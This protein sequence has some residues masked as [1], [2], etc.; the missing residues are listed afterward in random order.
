MVNESIQSAEVVLISE[1]GENVGTVSREQAFFI[2][3]ELGLD[4]VVVSNKS[5]P[6]V[7]RLKDVG[8]ERYELEKRARKHKAAQRSGELKE[9]QLSFRID[10]HDFQTKLRHAQRFLAKGDRIKLFMRL[11]GRENAFAEQAKQ[12]IQEFATALGK[13]VDTLDKQGSRITAI[14]K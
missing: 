8:K 6:P 9:I 13:S 12:R 10:D 14:L 3:H 11:I 5:T 7:V 4:V 2:A 1:R